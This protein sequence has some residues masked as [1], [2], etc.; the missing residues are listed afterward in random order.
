MSLLITGGTGFVLSHVVKQW[1]EKNSQNRVVVV[2]T[3]GLDWEAQVFFGPLA[4]R[5]Q[6]VSAD[7]L[8][9]ESWSKEFDANLIT[10]VIHGAA[11]SPISTDPSSSPDWQAPSRTVR[12]NVMGTVAALDWVR[13]LKNLKR[14]LYMSS[15][16]YG[17]G[18]KGL[19]QVGPE[20]AIDEDAPLEPQAALYDISKA[21]SE[22]LVR[23]YSELYGFSYVCVRPS[24][25][26][27]PLDRDTPSRTVH[28]LPFH[29]AHAAASGKKYFSVNC[30]DASYDWVYAPDVA[31][32]ILYLLSSAEPKY[33][34][35]NIGYGRY[36]T[37]NDLVSGVR[38]TVPDFR[39][40][41]SGDSKPDYFQAVGMR[42][43]VWRVRSTAR[44]EEEFGWHPTPH[45]KALGDYVNWIRRCSEE[46]QVSQ[47]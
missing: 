12:I 10:R 46:R 3:S 21:I 45:G 6:L 7:V 44:L 23:R 27:G 8:D 26:Y 28:P 33:S 31:R 4:R 32:A 29:M 16:V 1:L 34:T 35:Y 5:I 17:Y 41:E 2:D 11:V 25:V 36:S 42:G 37:V 47:E 40:I 20:P 15:G 14:F 30:L 43:G 13:Q 18:K 38:T 22:Q 39:V 9:P 24:A 19:S